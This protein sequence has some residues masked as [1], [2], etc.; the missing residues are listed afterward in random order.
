MMPEGSFAGA[1][2]CTKRPIFTGN[3]TS[4]ARAPDRC[5]RMLRTSR[6]GRCCRLQR[7]AEASFP[8]YRMLPARKQML[9]SREH[10]P[11]TFHP[12]DSKNLGSERER[13]SG[14][15]AWPLR[16]DQDNI[17]T[18]SATNGRWCQHRAGNS[19]GTR[20]TNQNKNKAIPRLTI[21]PLLTLIDVCL[22]EQ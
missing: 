20:S 9:H 3:R 1:T 7:R 19:D 22:L 12:P 18:D 6:T 15:K 11:R 10:L 13:A 2:T 4:G 16:A 21:S 5:E 17:A 14:C 8:S